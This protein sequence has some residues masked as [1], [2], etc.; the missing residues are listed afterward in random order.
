MM[1]AWYFATALA[2]QYE[3]VLPYLEGKRLSDW[4]HI[5]TTEAGLLPVPSGILSGMPAEKSSS[6]F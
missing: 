2:E 6:S 3:S 4:V 1:I 5:K